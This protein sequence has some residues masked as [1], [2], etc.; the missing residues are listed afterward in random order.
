MKQ[1]KKSNIFGLILNSLDTWHNYSCI[2]INTK[3]K[4]KQTGWGLIKCGIDVKNGKNKNKK[5]TLVCF[6]G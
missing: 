1:M 6:Y 2:F 4:N 5:I 3:W